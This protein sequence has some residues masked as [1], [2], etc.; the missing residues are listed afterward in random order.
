MQGGKD[1]AAFEELESIDVFH[2]GTN[3]RQANRCGASVQPGEF[4][5]RVCDQRATWVD[6]A[7]SLYSESGCWLTRGEIVR[8]VSDKL[9]G[10]HV[11]D[12]DNVAEIKVGDGGGG[13]GG[14]G[15]KSKAKAF[16]IPRE[17]F[18]RRI[19]PRGSTGESVDSAISIVLAKN[20]FNRGSAPVGSDDHEHFDFRVMKMF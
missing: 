19:V 10:V 14:R 1:A 16:Q 9:G 7:L 18:E 8:D 4:R 5:P 17:G 3:V 20:G 6:V 11:P 15:V 13:K 12:S 2:G